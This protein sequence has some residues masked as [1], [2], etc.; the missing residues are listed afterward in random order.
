MVKQL[1][2]T[3]YIALNLCSTCFL[4]VSSY[5]YKFVKT[6]KKKM[7]YNSVY[8]E[9]FQ[10]LFSIYSSVYFIPA[11]K[12]KCGM[13]NGYLHWQTDGPGTRLL[14]PAV[15]P[16]LPLPPCSPSLRPAT[17]HQTIHSCLM[18]QADHWSYHFFVHLLHSV[19]LCLIHTLLCLYVHV[20]PSVCLFSCVCSEWGDVYAVIV[21]THTAALC[22]SAQRGHD[23]IMENGACQ[24]VLLV[25]IALSLQR[26]VRFVSKIVCFQQLPLPLNGVSERFSLV[27]LLLC[28]PYG[29]F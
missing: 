18:P 29:H 16:H 4:S 3:K 2:Y 7:E 28:T 6:L 15:M 9:T 27:C 14:H 25:W 12:R 5:P 21:Q 22:W 13:G 11:L 8:R 17:S 26:R 20:L 19:S 23:S 1:H 24:N 10:R